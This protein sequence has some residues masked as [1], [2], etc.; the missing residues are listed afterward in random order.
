MSRPDDA[1]P[2]LAEVPG[3]ARLVHAYSP[4]EAEPRQAEEVSA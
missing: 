2:L 1:E 3:Y 4:D